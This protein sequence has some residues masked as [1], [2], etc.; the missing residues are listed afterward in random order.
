MKVVLTFIG[1]FLGTL[2][3]LAPEALTAP[4]SLDYDSVRDLYEGLLRASHPDW[5]HRLVRKDNRNPQFR[6]RFGRRSDPALLDDHHIMKPSRDD[7]FE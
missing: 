7:Y 4:T 1:C 3:S 2:I 5:D 6:L